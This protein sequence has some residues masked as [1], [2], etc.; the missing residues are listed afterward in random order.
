MSLVTLLHSLCV[1]SSRV[2]NA[3]KITLK[4]DITKTLYSLDYGCKVWQSSS[5]SSAHFVI[6][7]EKYLE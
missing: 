3:V 4:K 5:I 6:K 2:N 1:P 7:L